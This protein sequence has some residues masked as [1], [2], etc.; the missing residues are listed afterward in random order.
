MVEVMTAAFAVNC[1]LL[2]YGYADQEA[3]GYAGQGSYTGYA[4]GYGPAQ[5]STVGIQQGGATG[6]S[7]NDHTSGNTIYL[8]S[9][10]RGQIFFVI[11][12]KNFCSI[13]L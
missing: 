6:Y 8:A 3:Q 7:G 10:F 2:L 5:H 9:Y 13:L 12:V 1:F 11:F 4:Q